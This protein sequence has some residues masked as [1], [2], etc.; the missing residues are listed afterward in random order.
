MH[1]GVATIYS[2]KFLR[3]SILADIYYIHC[4]LTMLI[5]LGLIFDKSIFVKNIHK[6]WAPQKLVL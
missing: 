4:V 3:G 6:N 1:C 5:L 2:G